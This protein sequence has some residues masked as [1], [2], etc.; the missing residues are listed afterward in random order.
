M[1]YGL[2]AKNMDLKACPAVSKNLTPLNETHTI[3]DLHGNALKLLNFLMMQ[4][5]A[6]F[7]GD[8][9][10]NKKKYDQFKALYDKPATRLKA[11]DL[12]AFK[13]LLQDLEFAPNANIRLIGDDLA[14]R[15]MNDYY[16]LLLINKLKEQKVGVEVILSNHAAE[17]I[18]LQET[19]T[20]NIAKKKNYLSEALS[21]EDEY[22]KDYSQAQSAQNLDILLERG[23]VTQKEVDALYGKYSQSVKMLSYDLG[24]DDELHIHSHAP[25]NEIDILRMA[26]CLIQIHDGKSAEGI[27]LANFVTS[28][29]KKIIENALSHAKGE[30]KKTL[31]NQDLIELIDVIN[32]VTTKAAAAEQLSVMT[33]LGIKDGQG[34]NFGRAYGNDG[35]NPADED[36][37][38]YPFKFTYWNRENPNVNKEGN[39][40]KSTCDF[41][42]DFGHI[43]QSRE[44]EWRNR[45]K[46]NNVD[47]NVG[48]PGINSGELR[49]MVTKPYPTKTA[50]A[51]P[52]PSVTRPFQTKSMASVALDANKTHWGILFP[53]NNAEIYFEKLKELQKKNKDVDGATRIN[54]ALEDAVW[55][56]D[57]TSK[58]TLSDR[59]KTLEELFSAM[60]EYEYHVISTSKEEDEK[61]FKIVVDEINKLQKQLDDELEN[62][63]RD[64]LV[65]TLQGSLKLDKPTSQAIATEALNPANVQL[66]RAI[67][68][69]Q[70]I[71]DEFAG[72][73]SADSVKEMTDSLD[74]LEKVL[75]ANATIAKSHG[76]KIQKAIGAQKDI[77]NQLKQRI[78]GEKKKLLIDTLKKSLNVNDS[79]SQAIVT[80]SL[81]TGS[82][83]IVRAIMS[84]KDAQDQL[85]DA[86]SG[87][88]ISQAGVVAQM[89][90]SLDSLQTTLLANAT[91]KNNH[92]ATIKAAVDAQKIAIAKSGSPPPKPTK[93]SWEDKVAAVLGLPVTDAACK[94]LAV[95]TSGPSGGT[96][97]AALL[98]AYV[99]LDAKDDAEYKKQ[100]AIGKGQLGNFP[101]LASHTASLGKAF[102]NVIGSGPSASAA[103]SA[104]GAKL[105]N[106]K[107]SGAKTSA[108]G[109]SDSARDA[110]REYRH[111]IDALIEL[112]EQKNAAKE[113]AFIALVVAAKVGEIIPM[114]NDEYVIVNAEMKKAADLKGMIRSQNALYEISKGKTTEYDALT[115]DP[116]S[117]SVGAFKQKMHE[118]A[119]VKKWLVTEDLPPAMKA[120]IAGKE[121]V[122]AITSGEK[123]GLKDFV[124]V[125]DNDSN[126][127]FGDNANLCALLDKDPVKVN[128]AGKDWFIKGRIHKDGHVEFVKTD[129]PTPGED[130]KNLAYVSVKDVDAFASENKGR[131]LSTHVMKTLGEK[132]RNDV[133]FMDAETSAKLRNT[134]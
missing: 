22:G 122:V 130:T 40:I 92:E 38:V 107:S 87:D 15:G 84:V 125:Y 42:N 28:A 4:G 133:T 112:F 102:D 58:S 88:A 48:R 21:K 37:R 80:E 34:L 17:F 75:L 14:D 95:A 81:K 119:Q 77:Q 61:I 131:S 91:I 57:K 56:L 19:P 32:E 67:N 16:T 74:E 113:S 43:S 134:P 118:R 20:D 106:S 1:P 97:R 8:Q 45:P 132:L 36:A 62:E 114:E 68:K 101:A 96:L 31:N 25:I 72:E 65:K 29:N 121:H 71:I 66:Y 49:V 108:G 44:N 30:N 64:T 93:I 39:N 24:K 127:V 7:K 89:T 120:K 99:A 60:D 11:D 100:M 63:K 124:K 73:E 128:I 129:K 2:D 13:A 109:A 69:H 79:V 111:N 10:E 76:A 105:M 3:G 115:K 123:H 70:D 5:V 116:D 35:D 98:D 23:L 6:K 51:K 18:K 104:S 117:K 41:T 85:A 86:Q 52:P 54:Q 55:A 9:Q 110:R 27:F 53:K 90:K 46:G 82:N 59:I 26:M 94:A 33:D 126:T 12:Q 47:S 103:A 50:G 83:T 78:E